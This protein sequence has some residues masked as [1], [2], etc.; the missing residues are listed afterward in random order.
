MSNDLR[1]IENSKGFE[2]NPF[3]EFL[4]TKN[5]WFFKNNRE[6]LLSEPLQAAFT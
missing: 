2:R 3:R 1:N 5:H 6:S 4:I